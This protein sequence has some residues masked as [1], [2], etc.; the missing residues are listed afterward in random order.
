MSAG[1]VICLKRGANELYVIQ[2][3]PLPSHRLLLH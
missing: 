3:M 2:M 1:V